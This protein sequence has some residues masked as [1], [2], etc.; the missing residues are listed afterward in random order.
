MSSE[1]AY[2]VEAIPR[3]VF[4]DEQFLVAHYIAGICSSMGGLILPTHT[5]CAG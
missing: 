1:E 5:V 4:G 3:R 2:K